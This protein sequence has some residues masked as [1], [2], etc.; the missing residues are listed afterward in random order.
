M[1]PSHKLEL[2][3]LRDA[4]V[5]T[6]PE[7]R[8]TSIGE[9]FNNISRA[10]ECT[11]ALLVDAM[12]RL[13]ADGRLRLRKWDFA[14]NRF[15]EY[16]EFDAGDVEF[17]YRGDFRLLVTPQGRPYYEALLADAADQPKS[18]APIGFSAPQRR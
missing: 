6:D 2:E 15:V 16:E 10:A 9:L 12:K 18:K 3:I 11:N 8:P 13:H 1:L 14:L 5:V 17:F 4:Q 7:G